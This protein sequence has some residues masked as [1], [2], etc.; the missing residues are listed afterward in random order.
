MMHPILAGTSTL[1]QEPAEAFSGLGAA[2]IVDS[3]AVEWPGGAVTVL[4]D[5]AADRAVTSSTRSH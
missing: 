3:L 2:V 1:G 5:V 4:S